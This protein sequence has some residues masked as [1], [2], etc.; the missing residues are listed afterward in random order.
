MLIDS[1]CHINALDKDKQDAVIT[2]GSTGCIFV[3]SSIDLKN[4]KLS[5]ELSA[6]HENIYSA[7]GFHP[8]CVK[9]YNSQTIDD[10]QSLISNNKKIVAVG[11]IGLDFKADSSPL[12]QESVFKEFIKLAKKNDLAIMIHNRSKSMRILDVI[13]DFYSSYE[14]VI[15]H[16]FSYSTDFLDR[17]ID[18]KG[19]VSFSLNILR[20]NKDIIASLKRCPLESILLETDSPYMRIDNRLSTPLDIGEVYKFSAEIKEIEQSKLEEV[21][22][23]NVERVLNIS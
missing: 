23:S 20:K 2:G 19:F 21:I 4:S 6:K 1:H 15:F 10:Y 17:I 22:Y 12:E 9:E 14:K 18:K 8:F 11:E 16:C 3:D 5:L 7:L 13:D